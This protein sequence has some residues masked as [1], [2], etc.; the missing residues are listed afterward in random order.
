MEATLSFTIV[1]PITFHGGDYEEWRR[2]IADAAKLTATLGEVR[3][4]HY[5][6]SE[7]GGISKLVLDELMRERL[8]LEALNREYY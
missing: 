8:R 7:R 6:L 4:K 3:K 1:G 2:S 5:R